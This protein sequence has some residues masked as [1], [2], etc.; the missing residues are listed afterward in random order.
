MEALSRSSLRGLRIKLDRYMCKSARL[1]VSHLHRAAQE[2]S[3]RKINKSAYG[4]PW[5]GEIKENSVLR[6][7]VEMK[8]LGAGVM[9]YAREP[10]ARATSGAILSQ[11]F[12]L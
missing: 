5:L 3:R 8:F 2:V 10:C 12:L 6:V 7:F 4:N 1:Q 11:W 9:G